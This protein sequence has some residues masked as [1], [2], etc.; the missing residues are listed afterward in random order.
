MEQVNSMAK[1]ADIQAQLR[2]VAGGSASPATAVPSGQAP[3]RA[4]APSAAAKAPSREGRVHI[5]AYLHPDFKRSLMRVRAETGE[6]VQ[7][8]VARALNDLFRAHNVPVVDQK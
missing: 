3:A 8:L 2:A 4:P 1:V 5:G 6:D 7:S